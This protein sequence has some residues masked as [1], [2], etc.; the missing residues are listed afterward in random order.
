MMQFA[1]RIKHRCSDG[2]D[3]KR[4]TDADMF[5]KMVKDLPGDLDLNFVTG[6]VSR[7][8]R[9]ER[10]MCE[11]WHGYREKSTIRSTD[12]RGN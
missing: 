11:V 7:I 6:F 10:S 12:K 2:L 1:P 8:L 9:Q 4:C 3:T 5:V